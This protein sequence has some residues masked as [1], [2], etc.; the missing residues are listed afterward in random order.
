[1]VTL[2]RT[3]PRP[4][5]VRLDRWIAIGGVCIAVMLGVGVAVAQVVDYELG[6]RSFALDSSSDRSLVGGLT[7]LLLTAATAGAW[8]LAATRAEQRG[9]SIIG[10]LC[11]TTIVAL[12]LSMVPHAALLAAPFAAGAFVCLWRLAAGGSIAG[13][14]VRAACIVLGVSFVAH[15]FGGWLVTELGRGGDSWI[16]QIKVIV[17]HGSELAGWMLLATGLASMW[18][19]GR[20]S[21]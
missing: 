11:L 16:Y 14:V 12:K 10:A 13:R 2:T 9:T 6:L 4:D 8:L 18:I 3:V 19:A 7:M 20:R 17:K 1:M 21:R 5:G 15:V